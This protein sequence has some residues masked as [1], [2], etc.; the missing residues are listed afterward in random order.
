MKQI[1]KRRKILVINKNDYKF[2][3][4]KNINRVM[5]TKEYACFIITHGALK[6]VFKC[7]KT[8]SKGIIYNQRKV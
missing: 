1:I 7:N 6:N 4:Q 2:I 8:G 3:A 5:K